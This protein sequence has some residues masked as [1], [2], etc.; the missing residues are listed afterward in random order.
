MNDY[1]LLMH[2]DAVDEKVDQWPAWLDRLASEGR[3]RGGS[4]IA[5]GECVRRDGQP[6]RPL[7]SLTGFV[8]IAATDLEDAKT[9]LVGNPAYEGGGTVEFRLL[10]EDD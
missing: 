2:G 4:S 8:R 5:G 6:K 10:L 9:C 1:L 7:S 3:L